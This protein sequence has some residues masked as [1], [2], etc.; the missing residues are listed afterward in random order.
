MPNAQGF[1][2]R[3]LPDALKEKTFELC[4][5]GLQIKTILTAL[6]RA[7]GN[8]KEAKTLDALSSTQRAEHV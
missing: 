2:V 1:K 3:F 5:G 8:K 4:G 7:V 6:S